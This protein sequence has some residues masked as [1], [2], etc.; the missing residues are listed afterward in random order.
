[1]Y[2]VLSVKFSF[3]N[4]LKACVAKHEH[5]L[6][7]TPTNSFLCS[8]NKELY[9]IFK[10]CCTILV[11]SNSVIRIVVLTT[12]WFKTLLPSLTKLV[13]KYAEEHEQLS[14]VDCSSC[15]SI[16]S[17]LFR[18]L[19]TQQRLVVWLLIVNKLTYHYS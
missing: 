4:H 16:I 8:G 9:S 1:M 18:P 11:F 13:P 19:L 12:E 5:T 7:N 6:E 10:T 2:K 14:A 3:L 15:F 17:C